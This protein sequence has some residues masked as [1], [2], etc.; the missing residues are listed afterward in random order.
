MKKQAKK[1]KQWAG[2]RLIEPELVDKLLLDSHNPRFAATAENEKQDSLLKVLWSEF[3]V[4]EV[5]LSIAANGFFQEEPLLVVPHDRSKPDGPF[6]VVEGNRRLAAVLLLRDNE[7]RKKI[8]ALNLPVLD[9][10]DRKRL[11]QLPVSKYG[12]REEIWRYLG[13]RHINGPQPW[14]AFSKAMYVASLHDDLD[15]SL[16]E[17]ATS[18]GDRHSTVKRLYRGYKILQQ[19]ETMTSF[20]RE[21]RT[22]NK[23]FFSHLYTAVDQT[24]FQRH[25]GI[26]PEKSL[27][28]NPVT[29]QRLKEL[30]ELMVW[31]YGSKAERRQPLVQKQNPDLNVLREVISEPRGLEAL[32]AGYSLPRAL[33]I[34]IGDEQRFR[35]ALIRAK[36]ELQIADG[37]LTTGYFGEQDTYL[38]FKDIAAIVDSMMDRIESKH[39][40][41][42]SRVEKMKRG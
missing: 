29:K 32:R 10:N 21:D 37:T 16:D 42:I 15:V 23:F 38:V 28:P 18:I 20:K 6:V 14:D 11:E 7:L 31:F 19:A 5:A 3:A 34:S 24:E 13:F 2:P 9:D 35:N 25:L 41:S 17:I 33:E 12:S 1:A 27:R 39:T 36:D 40:K 26:D 4:D 30:R 22:A 8:K